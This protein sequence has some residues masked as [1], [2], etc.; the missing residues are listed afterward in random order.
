VV[1]PLFDGAVYVAAKAQVPIVPVGIG[2]S[3][4]VMPKGTNV[5]YPRKVHVIVGPPI[6]PP[7]LQGKRVQRDELTA[8]SQALHAELQR[9]FD[10]AQARVGLLESPREPVHE[11]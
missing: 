1:Q 3:E 7:P 5:I 4:R 9:L 2:G 11:G 10:T 8:T 6:P